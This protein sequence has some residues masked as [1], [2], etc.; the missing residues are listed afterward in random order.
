MFAS[1]GEWL[2]KIEGRPIALEGDPISCPKCGRPGYIMCIAPRLNFKM[3]GKLPALEGDYCICGCMPPPQ[4]MANQSLSYQE[5]ENGPE[6]SL[7]HASAAAVSMS[8]NTHNIDAGQ[9]Y[10]F[11]DSE[12]QQPLSG[13]HYVGKVDGSPISG[14]TDDNGFAHID[15]SQGA[16]IELHLI[17]T[18][19]K[20]ALR[21][22]E[23]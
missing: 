21:H 12:T 5:V 7:G 3:D 15:A 13:R 8:G 22:Q 16:A 6:S 11:L 20:D 1:G 17:F 2:K 14:T 19:P 18:S 4:L 9:Q 10:Q 23:S